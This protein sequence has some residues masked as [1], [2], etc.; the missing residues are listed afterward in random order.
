MNQ[1]VSISLLN[2]F[3]MMIIIAGSIGLSIAIMILLLRKRHSQAV[4]FDPMHI[5]E[6]IKL[7]VSVA[8]FITVCI[9]LILLVYQNRTIVLQTR[10]SWQSVESNV[11]GI[12]TNQT[13]AE[14]QMFVSAPE[15]RPY[16]YHGKLLTPDDPLSEKV[17]AAAEYLLDYFDSQA[18]Q[19]KKY[20]NLWRSEKDAWE[21]NIIDQFA[22]SP[23]LCWYLEMN[24]NWWSDEL[25]ALKQK[26][27][28]KRKQ[29]NKEQPRFD[30]AK[31]GGQRL[32]SDTVRE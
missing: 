4:K 7:I 19:L 2:I 18:T 1:A 8:S 15:L 16:F 14:D 27:E 23:I 20:P 32:P 24:K 10:Y 21:A 13:L 28:E 30:G 26:G 11:F 17:K 6:L 22:W 25:F 12:V 5:S 3:I 9:T 29:G 31:D